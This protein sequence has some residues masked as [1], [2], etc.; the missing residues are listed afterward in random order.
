MKCTV[1]IIIRYRNVIVKLY[2]TCNIV[3][4]CVYREIPVSLDC[5]VCKDH[6]DHPDKHSM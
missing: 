5:L 6:L 2:I 3:N 4:S 1:L